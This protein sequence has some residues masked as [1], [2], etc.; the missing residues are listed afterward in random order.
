MRSPNL[1]REFEETAGESPETEKVI[2]G[3]GDG[4]SPKP[5]VSAFPCEKSRIRVGVR[6]FAL[7]VGNS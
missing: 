1:R 3:E 6:D 4:I 7:D 5:T 2:Y